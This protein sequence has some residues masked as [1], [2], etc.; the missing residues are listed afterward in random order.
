MAEE[1][2]Y[3]AKLGQDTLST[4]N[5]N[6]DGSGTLVSVA[7]ASLNGAIVKAVTITALGSCSQGM[8]RLFVYNG[9]NTTI[10]IGEI[11]VPAVTRSSREKGFSIVVPM[12]LNL[13]S[14]YYLKA[15]TQNA[16]SFNI[17]GEF[18]FWEYYSS[19]VRTDTTKYTSNTGSVTISTANSNTDGT[20][21]MGLVLTAGSSATYKGTKINSITIQAIGSTTP[22]IVR[23]FVKNSALT[24]SSLIKEVLIPYRTPSSSLMAFSETIYFGDDGFDLKSD[25]KIYA[26]TENAESFVITADAEDWNYVA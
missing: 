14:G 25:Q 9:S 20:G 17:L 8:I 12:N 23:I 16:D 21:T 15:S 22:G 3:T 13:K 24:K 26:S 2:Q 11:E 18:L 4:A 10:L 5:S 1:T 6:L 7:L 19:S